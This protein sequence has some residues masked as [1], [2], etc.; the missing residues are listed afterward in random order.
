[1][2]DAS[3]LQNPF[4]TAVD[5]DGDG[6]GGDSWVVHFASCAASVVLVDNAESGADYSVVN[7]NL[8]TGAWEVPPVV[9]TGGGA[10]NDPPTDFDGS[11]K[12]F[13]TQD[14]PGDQDVDGGPTRLIS[15]AF[16]LSGM[17][18]PYL[19]YA[20]WL[21]S[22]GTDVLEVD[23][24][25]NNGSSWVPVETVGTLGG[26]DVA[27]LRVSDHV[28]PSAQTRLRF[29]V[30]DVS[31]GSITEAGIDFLR[32]VAVDCAI[33][34]PVGTSYCV[35]A[36]NSAGAGAAIRAEGS[37]VLAVNDLELITEG[38]PAGVNGIYFFGGS[39]IQTPF[40]DGFLC[41]GGSLTRL[42][43]AQAS[44]AGGVARRVVDLSAP[45]VAGLVS[46][47]VTTRFQYWYR[48]TAAGNTGFN[49]SDGLR[50]TWQ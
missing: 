19:S 43:P 21:V 1:M 10:R 9:P 4:G 30:E 12:C 31:P 28:S 29:S 25:S 13:V 3:I 11:G 37:E 24:S 47:G 41:V 17:A 22:S 48:D 15:R 46:P 42:P 35:G 2:A 7:E 14:G 16:D 38:L 27:T 34:D 45:P 49:T 44:D 50:V 20:R 39:A 23:I 33:G 8:S 26:W 40:G 6:A 36:P 5:G 18:D 32:V